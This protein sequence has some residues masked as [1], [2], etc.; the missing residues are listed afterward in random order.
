MALSVADAVR[1]LG[2]RASDD[3]GLAET[4]RYLADAVTG[5]DDPFGRPPEAVLAAARGVNERRQVERAHARRAD[6]LDT[7]AVVEAISS[8]NDRRGVDRRRRRGQLLGWPSG[9][10]TLHPAWQFDPSRGDT[11]P[12]LARVIAALREA[13][14]DAQAA[15]ELMRA[16]REDLDHRSLADLFAAG[17]VQTVIRLVLASADES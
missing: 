1:V 15:D 8:V 9:T 5:P 6:A 2:E 11:R 3:P 14:P 4:L 13:T 12:G 7:A 10:Q 16:P 17:Q